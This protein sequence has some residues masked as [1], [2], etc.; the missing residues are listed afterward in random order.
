MAT[1]F[2]QVESF[3]GV[4]LLLAS[5]SLI[6]GSPTLID[7]V[8][9]ALTIDSVIKSINDAL[10]VV[11]SF[12]KNSSEVNGIKETQDRKTILKVDGKTFIFPATLSSTRQVQDFFIE[13]EKDVRIARAVAALAEA[14]IVDSRRSGKEGEN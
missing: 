13:A 5:A 12:Q 10:R 7:R 14:L 11:E 9:N 2:Y 8:A 3:R 4:S 1:K 6:T